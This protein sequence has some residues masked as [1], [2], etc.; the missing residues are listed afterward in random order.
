MGFGFSKKN[1]AKFGKFREVEP[2]FFWGVALEW[3][4]LKRGKSTEDNPKS[5]NSSC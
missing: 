1:P 4:H 5:C 2:G 3:Y